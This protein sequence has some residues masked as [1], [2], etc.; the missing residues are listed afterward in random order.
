MPAGALID[1]ADGN[2]TVKGRWGAVA[3]L[4]A[5]QIGAAVQSASA[6]PVERGLPSLAGGASSTP[7]LQR[8]CY[9][10]TTNVISRICRKGATMPGETGPMLGWLGRVPASWGE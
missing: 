2:A 7:R 10:A 6:G 1:L 3:G 4:S 9:E 5:G 8:R